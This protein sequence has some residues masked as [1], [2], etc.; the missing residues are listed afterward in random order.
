MKEFIL[1]KNDLKNLCNINKNSIKNFENEE[2]EKLYNEFIDKPAID[3]R[4]YECNQENFFYLDLS[5]M[6]LT[7]NE[8]NIL[9]NN[10]EINSLLNKIELL[11][12]SKNNLEEFP[13]FINEFKNIKFLNIDENIIKGII[14]IDNLKEL[15]CEKNNIEGVISSSLKVLNSSKNKLRY[16]YCPYIEYLEINDNEIMELPIL[17]KIEHLNVVNTNIKKINYI[18]TLREL[19]CST[20]IISKEFRIKNIELINNI[21]YVEFNN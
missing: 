12:I 20:N 10:D 14:Q 19:Q 5:N 1:K 4:I 21:Y 2:I 7:N 13:I 16:I 3:Y 8:L 15:S 17:K 6:N 11:D 9:I 18:K